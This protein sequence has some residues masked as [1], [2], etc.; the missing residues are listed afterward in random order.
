MPCP[1]EKFVG[2]EPGHRHARRDRRRRV[3]ALGFEEEQPAAVHVRLALGHRRGPALAHLR[4]RRDRIGA[5]RLARR[6]LHRHHGGAAVEGLAACR[7]TAAPSAR[8]RGAASSSSSLHAPRSRPVAG[9]RANCAPLSQTIAPV[10][11]RST[12]RSLGQRDA[13]VVHH[14]DAARDADQP[15]R[16]V[17]HALAAR[18]AR[19]RALRRARR[20][21]R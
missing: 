14:R 16:R 18:R 5:R 20:R 6:G 12:A 13:F 7:G 4:R 10:G 1:L 17:L 9:T 11:H 3:L 15:R 21:R 2:A 19:H 8:R